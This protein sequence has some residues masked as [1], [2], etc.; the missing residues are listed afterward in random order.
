MEEIFRCAAESTW[1]T[2]DPAI[3]DNL[4]LARS[5][6]PHELLQLD[7][8]GSWDPFLFREGVRV[9][10]SFSLVQRDVSGGT[11][12][13]HPLVH[14]W[15]RERMSNLEQEKKCRS[16]NA[17]LTCSINFQFD[18]HHREFRRKLTPHISAYRERSAGAKVPKLCNYD[19]C[20]SYQLVFLENGYLKEAEEL[21]AQATEVGKRILGLEHPDT[22]RGMANL[23][24]TYRHQ[25][26][27]EEAE[28]LGVQVTEARKR[29]LGLEH[30]G[31]LTSM[32]N[33]ASTYRSQGRL[34]EAEGLEVQVVEAR[35]RILGL[36]HPDTLTSMG[37]LASVYIGQGCLGEAERLGVHVFE[38][39]EK[40]LG[41]DNPK[42]L[43]SMGDL[44]YTWKL[45]GRD[46]EAIDLMAKKAKLSRERLGPDHPLTMNAAQILC[47]WRTP[48]KAAT[49]QPP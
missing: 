7:E 34:R 24:S 28:E 15:A 37:K 17:L 5:D 33:V 21:G 12:S 2:Y 26:R 4:S 10:Q 47:K 41:A 19:E 11:Y 29:I 49:S 27:L 1:P 39:M 16:A 22:L 44:A 13:V 18:R 30:P 32:G 45:Q 9:L 40:V 42:T 35:K 46:E 6:L 48:Q 25:G 20:M 8:K 3:V 43:R 31:T 23:A 38:M 36:E 14:S